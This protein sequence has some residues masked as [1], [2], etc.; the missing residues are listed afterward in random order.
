M[1]ESRRRQVRRPRSPSKDRQIED[2]KL[3]DSVVILAV[4]CFD[5]VTHVSLW[6]IMPF[7]VKVIDG[8]CGYDTKP[9]K[10]DYD[11]VSTVN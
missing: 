6:L 8:R 1:V 2:G 7:Q 10:S 4:S 11:E 5:L 9:W 3:R